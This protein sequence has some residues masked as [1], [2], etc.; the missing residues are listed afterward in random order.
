MLDVYSESLHGFAVQMSDADAQALAA[1][2]AVAAVEENAV[3]SIARP[4]SRRRRRGDSTASTSRTLPLDTQ[5]T[6][7]SDGTGVHAYVIDTGILTT[8]IDFGGRASSGDDE[9]GTPAASRNA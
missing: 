2:P 7:G 8:H 5:Y 6:Y 3:V 1:D 4:R 9:I